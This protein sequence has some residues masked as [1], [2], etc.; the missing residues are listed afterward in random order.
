MK[1]IQGILWVQK[2]IENFDSLYFHLF[3]SCFI[4]FLIQLAFCAT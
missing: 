1:Q 2:K 4:T 3:V